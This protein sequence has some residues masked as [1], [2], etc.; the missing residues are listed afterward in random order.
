MKTV[1]L[2]IA[3]LVIGCTQS[4]YDNLMSSNP[5]CINQ[6]TRHDPNGWLLLQPEMHFVFYGQYWDLTAEPDAYE[7]TWTEL[8]NKGTLLQRLSEYGI[9]SGTLDTE[10]YFTAQDKTFPNSQVTVIDDSLIVN[11]LIAQIT[12]GSVPKP[13]P[14]TIYSIMLPP[15]T[16]TKF[17]L[18]NNS[19]AYHS[20]S[21]YGAERFTY[22]ISSYQYKFEDV[23]V[24][25]SH[26]L[27]EAATDPN[28]NG[29]FQGNGDE[30][31][32]LCEYFP[33]EYVDGFLVSKVW[34]EASCVCL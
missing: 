21:S 9:S 2:L 7:Y 8:L 20:S 17:M 28:W 10:Y 23:N 34:S 30:V 1:A 19:A 5:T 22:S 14:N 11:D 27:Y 26:E 18:D 15:N 16:N 25:L 6:V 12:S 3:C 32:D 13:N 4:S 31:A 29:F 24:F 33:G